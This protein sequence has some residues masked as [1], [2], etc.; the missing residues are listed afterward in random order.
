VIVCVERHTLAKFPFPDA[1]RAAIAPW[2]MTVAEA[3]AAVAR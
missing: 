1:V 2:V 3:R